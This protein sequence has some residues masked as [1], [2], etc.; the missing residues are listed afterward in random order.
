M[1]WLMYLIAGVSIIWIVVI[2]GTNEYIFAAVVLFV[3]FVGYF[4]IKQVGIFTSRYEDN[5]LVIDGLPKTETIILHTETAVVNEKSK[6]SKSGMSDDT[7]DKIHQELNSLMQR[8]KR[9]TDPE[10]TLVQLSKELNIHA[11]SLS[12]VINSV[13]QKNFYDYVNAQRIEEFKKIVSSPENQKF[14]LLSLAFECGFNSKTSFNRNFKK[15][16]G[17]SPSEYIKQQ[18]ICLP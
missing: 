9:Y 10:L 6:Y 16:I 15:H 8:E 4:G 12:Q 13:E 17:I 11:N 1:S 2:F 14:T 3:L 7:I 5:D 18:N